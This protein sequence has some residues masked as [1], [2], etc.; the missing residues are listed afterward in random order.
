MTEP[1][2]DPQTVFSFCT[3]LV[4]SG[5]FTRI[6]IHFLPPGH[7][8]GSLD[9]K[10]GVISRAIGQHDLLTPDDVM[11]AVDRCFP[12]GST[13]PLQQRQLL[14]DLGNFDAFLALKTRTFHI[15][16]L[17]TSRTGPKR[18]LHAFKIVSVG[19]RAGI[20]YREH[21]EASYKWRGR[22]DSPNA[23]APVPIYPLKAMSSEFPTKLTRVRKCAIENLELI[24]RKVDAVS[25][26]VSDPKRQGDILARAA[27]PP[28]TDA[29]IAP[30]PQAGVQKFARMA[31]IRGIMDK[32]SAYWSGFFD[33]HGGVGD[34][35]AWTGE[36]EPSSCQLPDPSWACRNPTVIQKAC[37]IMD[38]L[39]APV[40]SDVPANMGLPSRVVELL[41]E[42]RKAE[43]DAD[44]SPI[45]DAIKD[46]DLHLHAVA[47][48]LKAP[49]S[50]GNYDPARDLAVGHIAFI[51][52]DSNPRGWD[53]GLVT[54][55]D[56]DRPE[57]EDEEDGEPTGTSTY[58]RIKYLCPAGMEKVYEEGLPWADNWESGALKV[59]QLRQ[60]VQGRSGSRKSSKQQLRWCDWVQAVDRA[61][62]QFSC[63]HQS[64]SLKFFMKDLPSVRMVLEQMQG[65]RAIG[66]QTVVT[67]E[68]D[69]E[70][71]SEEDVS[72]DDGL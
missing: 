27:P 7:T 31:D 47:P 21:D 2:Y 50:N 41:L 23:D 55:V 59:I 45:R 24:K 29:T 10:F 15:K 9:Q 20:L 35:E 3:W 71:G 32:H 63:A 67:V 25:M 61:T 1:V 30:G 53:L 43:R 48:G 8:H 18:R 11:D 39:D 72:D 5:V 54:D 33:V 40:D 17:G 49:P 69:D 70:E 4:D 66:Q 14:Q 42:A 26:V 68:L 16:G 58:I 37:S 34:D 51:A 64:N 60:V 44:L 46:R 12:H 62:V 28:P 22:W 52:M 13:G 36:E 65:A 6:Y 57:D 56:V 19:G 38:L